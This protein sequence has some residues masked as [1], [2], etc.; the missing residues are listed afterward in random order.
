M[1][2]YMLLNLLLSCNFKGLKNQRCRF[3]FYRSGVLYSKI[4][5]IIIPDFLDFSF[6]SIFFHIRSFKVNFLD[7]L[8][9]GLKQNT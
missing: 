6:V 4:K 2:F 1:K 5:S 7:L 8:A 3:D 9:T